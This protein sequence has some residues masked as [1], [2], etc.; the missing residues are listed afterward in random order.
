MGVLHRLEGEVPMS[1]DLRDRTRCEASRTAA[2]SLL[3]TL[4]D[5][6]EWEH[7]VASRVRAFAASTASAAPSV[8]AKRDIVDIATR[9]FH[10]DDTNVG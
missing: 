9:R 8:P 3:R 5:A 7:R 6:A 2:E 4:D 1:W 10:I